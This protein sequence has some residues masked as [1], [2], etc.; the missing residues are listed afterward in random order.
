VL[1]VDGSPAAGVPVTARPLAG[2]PAVTVFTDEAGRFAVPTVSDGEHALTARLGGLRSQAD[3]A[4]AGDPVAAELRLAADPAA[5]AASSAWLSLLPDG[6]EKRRFVLDCTGCHQLSGRVALVDGRPRT[7]EAW[8]EAIGRMLAFAGPESSFPVIAHGREPA[9][10]AEWLVRALTAAPRLR[11]ET[12]TGAAREAVITEY[13]VP[14][15]ELPHDLALDAEGRVVATG[16]F[17]HVMY[18]LDPRTGRLQELPIPVPNA[19]PRAL[20]IDPDGGWWV[21]L[22]NATSVARRDPADGSWRTWDIG[23]YPHSIGRGDDGRIWFNGHFT[24][25]PTLLASLDPATGAVDTVPMP[26]DPEWRAG[27]PIPYELR[28]GP[29][30]SVWTTELAGNRV[31][32]YSPG[33]GSF[34]T[35]RMPAEHSGPRRLD[36]A[37]DGTVWIPEYSGGKLARLDPSSGEIVEFDLP[38]RDALPYV[39]RVDRR[40]GVVW[41]AE[42]GADAVARFDP[43]SE[44]WLEIPLPAR[45]TL[46]RH[47]DVDHETGAVWAAYG[48]APPLSPKLARIELR[49]DA[50]ERDA[51]G[52]E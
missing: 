8:V 36:V 51:G 9:A 46:V 44:T 28:M 5:E 1:A 4:K 32:R 16:M 50:V 23:M 47:L 40:R 30:G 39:A 11:P 41:V 33:D 20:E 37:P 17:R 7:L 38:T 13:D 15:D 21:L 52:V 25:D 22:G 31:L 24:R 3:T 42:A 19:G 43:R 27:T 34:R 26:D 6:A 2:G 10:T 49:E 35:W 14:D 48:H 29:D 45:G 18:R 12:V